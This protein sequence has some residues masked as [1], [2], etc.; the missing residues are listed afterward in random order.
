MKW[1]EN[2]K[3]HQILSKWWDKEERWNTWMSWNFSCIFFHSHT[4]NKILGREKTEVTLSDT[5]LH[6]MERGYHESYL[7]Q[8]TQEEI[9][10]KNKVL[11]TI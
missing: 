10:E 3:K 9:E 4:F 1:G 7:E 2:I 6:L 8:D 5:E 11:L